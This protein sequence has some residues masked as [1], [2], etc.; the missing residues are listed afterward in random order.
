M[1]NADLARIIN[2]DEIQSAIRPVHS[3]VHYSTRKKNPL[4]NFSALVKLN[5]YALSQRR[6]VVLASQKSAEKRKAKVQRSRISKK[7]LNDVLLAPQA[8]FVD[9]GKHV[10][11]I[12]E[13]T[14]DNTK[15]VEEEPV[16]E[17]KKETP[18]TVKATTT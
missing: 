17:V 13:G 2:S 8:I 9:E 14:Y 5:P 15:V 10:E 7:Y 12:D 3:S 4:K 1:T 16:E 6:R 11:I 18:T